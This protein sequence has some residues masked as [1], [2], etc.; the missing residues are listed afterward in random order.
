M[1]E[2]KKVSARILFGIPLPLIWLRMA[3]TC[4]QYKKCSVMKASL[5]PKFIPIWIEIT[6]GI[7]FYSIIPAM[8]LEAISGVVF[9]EL[10]QLSTTHI[11]RLCTSILDQFRLYN[12]NN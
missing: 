4:A 3:P 12:G 8:H 1:P 5:R 10:F 11:P 9:Q 6:Y 7:T 2:S